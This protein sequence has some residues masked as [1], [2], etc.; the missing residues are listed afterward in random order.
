VH[1][2]AL[3][4]RLDGPGGGEWR[5]DLDGEG[6]RVSAADCAPAGAVW[7]Q[8]VDDWRGA[9]WG[10]GGGALGRRARAFLAGDR[11]TSRPPRAALWRG[12]RVLGRLRGLV[13]VTVTDGAEGDWAAAIRLGAGPIP[14]A[15]TV[16]I[17]ISAGAL[18]A[19][20]RRESDFVQAFLAGRIRVEGDLGLLL[21]MNAARRDDGG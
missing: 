2:L 6:V 8:T 3:G 17:A 18:D 11:L 10:E 7:V 14:E 12:L 1:G 21:R 13:R 16:S 15:P 19:I 9:L 20:D 5:V 4:V